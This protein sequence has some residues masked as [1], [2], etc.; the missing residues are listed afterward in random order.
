VHLIVAALCCALILVPFVL[1]YFQ[2]QQELGFERTLADNEPFSASLKQYLAVP[3]HSV[4]HGRWLPSDDTPFAGGYPVDA[5]FPGLVALGLSLWGLIRGRGRTRWFFLLLLLASFVLS[6]GPSLYVA[7]GKPAELDLTLPYAWLYAI[8][9][10]FK[11]LRAPV[12]FDALVML[13]LSVLAG[14]G[15]ATLRRAWI[16]ALLVGLVV[17][18]SLTWPAAK[19]EPVPVG[20]QVPAVY[21]WLAGQPTRA[22]L[23]LPMAFTSGG[24]QLEYQYFS[25]YHWHTTPDGYSGFVPAKHGQI[26]YEMESFPSERSIRLLQALEVRYVVIHTDRYPAEQWQQTEK[27]LGQAEDLSLIEIFGTDQIYEVAPHTFDPANLDVSTYLPPR[28]SAG[29]TY[30]A[31]VIVLNNSPWSY[32][33][34]PTDLIRPTAIWEA[35]EES[36][37]ETVSADVPLVTSGS[38]GASVIPV[39][40]TAPSEPGLYEFSIGEEEGPLGR[41]SAVGRVEVREEGDGPEAF[42]VPARLVEGAVPVTTRPGEPLPVDLEWQALGKIDAYYS[43]F[44]KLLDTEGRIIATWDGQP[45]NGE[46]PTLAWVPGETIEDTVV[47]ALADDVLPGDYVVQVGMYRAEDLAR[48]LLL[49][50][51]GVLVDHVIV[52]TVQIGP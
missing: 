39:P 35:V 49:A 9:P 31:F 37:R 30:T 46:A 22:I 6:L 20:D 5:L 34:Q 52:G 4:V 15:V 48:C 29:A 11:A 14:Y 7:P 27:D 43:I 8:I 47:L 40:L 16:P 50:K 17:V 1:P 44:V 24:P 28:A 2:V 13:S 3:P 38:G 21:R 41:W 12:R 42:P 45:Q 10:G 36:L 18:E 25:T 26:V 33:V 19:T 51:E 23:E 32:A